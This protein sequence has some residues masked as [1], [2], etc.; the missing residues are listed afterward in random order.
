VKEDLK[1]WANRSLA[2]QQRVNAVE[3]RD[4]DFPRNALGKVLKR[5]LRRLYGPEPA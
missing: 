2:E 3:F 1:E 4:E 5:G